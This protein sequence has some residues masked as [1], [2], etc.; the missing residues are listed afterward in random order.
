MCNNEDLGPITSSTV[1]HS[2]KAMQDVH[3][4]MHVCINFTVKLKYPC[5]CFTEAPALIPFE[6]SSNVDIEV[7]LSF[8]MFDLSKDSNQ[9]EKQQIAI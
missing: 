2:L 5:C 9:N 3:L 6:C 8:M 4:C 7:E 1:F